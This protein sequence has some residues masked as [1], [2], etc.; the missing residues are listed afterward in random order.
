M[1]QLSFIHDSKECILLFL[2]GLLSKTELGRKG[3]HGMH[4]MYKAIR[5][6]L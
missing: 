3:Y 5:S 6:I 4:S 1:K 2:T